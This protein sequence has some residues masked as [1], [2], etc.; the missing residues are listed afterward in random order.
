M[1]LP[2]EVVPSCLLVLGSLGWAD[3]GMAFLTSPNSSL[4]PKLFELIIFR[5]AKW[6]LSSAAITRRLTGDVSHSQS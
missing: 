2:G 4:I 1:S 6:N 3:Q 5:E